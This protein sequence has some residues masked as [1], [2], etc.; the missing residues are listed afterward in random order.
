MTVSGQLNAI[1]E[2]LRAAYGHQG[3]WPADSTE[4]VV[5]GAVLA[6]NVTWKNARRAIGELDRNRLLS[7][8]AIHASPCETIAP[9]IR[10]SRFYRQKAKRLKNFAALVAEE[11]KGDLPSMFSLD[12]ESLRKK[13]MRLKG[14]G[15]ETTDSILLYAAEKPVFVIDAYTRRIFSRLGFTPD[16]RS[17]GQ[18]QQFFTSRLPADAALFNDYHAQIVQLGSRL[19]LKNRPL[20]QN[21]PLAGRCAEAARRASA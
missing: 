20:C 3:W 4:E 10:S 16:N 17:Y 18:Y 12:T 8:A 19:C 6:Q 9:L 5:I 1:Y 13:I 15:E 2:T 21:C 11:Y 14:F 7:L